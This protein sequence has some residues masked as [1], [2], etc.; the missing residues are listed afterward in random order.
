MIKLLDLGLSLEC[1]FL[2]NAIS[3]SQPSPNLSSDMFAMDGKERLLCRILGARFDVTQVHKSLVD[4]ASSCRTKRHKG[5]FKIGTPHILQLQFCFLA[6]K[7]SEILIVQ[8]RN[9][10]S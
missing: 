2:A 3:A 10:Q 4:P 5:T 7:S 6:L 9:T 8:V 1:Q